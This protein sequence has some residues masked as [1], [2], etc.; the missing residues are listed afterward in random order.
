MVPSLTL[1]AL[2]FALPSFVVFEGI[3]VACDDLGGNFFGFGRC[4]RSDG[5]NG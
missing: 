5:H 1:I 4:A 2:K 3:A